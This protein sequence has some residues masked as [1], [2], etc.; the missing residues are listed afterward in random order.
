MSWFRR[1][2]GEPSSREAVPLSRSATH[3]RLLSEWIPRTGRTS[4]RGDER[5]ME[6]LR[7]QRAEQRAI[8]PIGFGLAL[9]V[10]IAVTLTL[11]AAFQVYVRVRG[12]AAAEEPRR[13]SRGPG[14]LGATPP[15]ASFDS[16]TLVPSSWAPPIAADLDRDGVED[17]VVLLRGASAEGSEVWVAGLTGRGYAPM[18]VRG[19]YEVQAGQ[20]SRLVQASDR[21]VLVRV[22]ETI[23]TAHVLTLRGGAELAAYALPR[24]EGAVC[25]LADGTRRVRAGGVVLDLD[26]G[27]LAAA[28]DGEHCAEER[29]PC[30]AGRKVECV[31]HDGLRV[32]DQVIDPAT[33][34]VDKDGW[35]TTVGPLQTSLGPGRPTLMAFGMHDGR[36]VWDEVVSSDD[37]EEDHSLVGASAQAAR[38][39]LLTRERPGKFLVRALDARTGDEQWHADVDQAAHTGV[40]VRATIDRVYV[41]LALGG[42]E[43]IQA[44]EA[45]SGKELGSIEAVTGA[46]GT[47]G[48]GIPGMGS[49]LGYRGRYGYGGGYPYGGAYP[50]S[51]PMVE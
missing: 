50:P 14:S 25:A 19:P 45:A 5:T 18:W 48:P 16:L 40:S 30:G 15:A 12:A 21:L 39:V 41:T 9:L 35:A 28:K 33:T 23:A 3:E 34:W 47:P 36:V 8:G 43:R 51:Y 31:S 49:K 11:V 38:L 13:A 44:Y 42:R 22:S 29:P 26:G 32:H 10:A 27:L 17:L 2:E 46:A 37:S 4:K 6:M 20:P 7:G 24:S 1:E